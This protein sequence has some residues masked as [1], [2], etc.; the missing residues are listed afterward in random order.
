M[1]RQTSVRNILVIS[2]LFLTMACAT[3]G[4]EFPK[5][6]VARIKIG[7]TTKEE[8]RQLF[9]APWRSGLE[10]GFQT[11]TYGTYRYQ[12]FNSPSTSDL[13]VRFDDNGVVTSY[14]FST[15]DSPDTAR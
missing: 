15:T 9:G 6:A 7:E 12:M 1:K 2:L 11:W 10:N 14:A 8:I 4:R 5:H 13:V 3:A